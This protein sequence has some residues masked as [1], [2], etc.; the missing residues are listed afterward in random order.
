M[1]TDVNWASQAVKAPYILGGIV[2]YC[3]IACQANTEHS[4]LASYPSAPGNE[5]VQP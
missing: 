4:A 5:D 2:F 3:L 1:I